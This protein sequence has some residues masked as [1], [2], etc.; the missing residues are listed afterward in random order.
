MALLTWPPGLCEC[1]QM[2]M[3]P[4]LWGVAWAG[5]MGRHQWVCHALAEAWVRAS[6]ARA[7]G[8]S[9]LV[10]ARVQAGFSWGKAPLLV[11]SGLGSTSVWPMLGMCRS[12]SCFPFTSVAPMGW[13]AS[14]LRTCLH[15][16]ALGGWVEGS[17]PWGDGGAAL[18]GDEGQRGLATW[19][20]G[21]CAQS[22]VPGP[23]PRRQG[24]PS[25]GLQA[26]RGAGAG[27][28]P[29]LPRGWGCASTAILRTRAEVCELPQAPCNS[30][31]S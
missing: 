30:L 21:I 25:R 18:P 19:E 29:R 12:P 17:W 1:P 14:F 7:C 22:N 28:G 4:S 2:W 27:L 24:R 26:P 16:T 10:L 5:A 6:S 13:P 31:R 9:Y 15:P 8:A 11:E 23:P 3:R 20:H